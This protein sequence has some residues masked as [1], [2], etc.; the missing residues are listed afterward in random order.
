MDN[1][2]AEFWNSGS[3]FDYLDYKENEKVKDDENLYQG[4]SNKGTDNR[5]E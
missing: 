4:L 3:V 1:K 2:W 5:G